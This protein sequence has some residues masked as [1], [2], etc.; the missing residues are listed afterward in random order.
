MVALA[1][2]ACFLADT[3]EGSSDNEDRPDQYNHTQDQIW[4]DHPHRLA[5]QNS[6][7]LACCLQR[8]YFG[9]R[10]SSVRKDKDGANNDAADGAE[11]IKGL[12]KVQAP[13]GRVRI[14][15]LSDKRTGAG[16]EKR[17]S[18]GD[19]EKRKQEKRIA[20]I[21]RGRPE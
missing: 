15:D 12:R 1:A 19:D 4:S 17:E 14:A 2:R 3:R 20:L 11:R 6:L 9:R 18:T 8:R 10:Q 21:R 7:I 5:A 16:F 13:L